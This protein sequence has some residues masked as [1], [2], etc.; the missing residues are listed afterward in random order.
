MS[1]FSFDIEIRSQVLIMAK[2]SLD[3]ED[4]DYWQVAPIITELLS[5]RE[6]SVQYPKIMSM[7]IL[8]FQDNT[9]EIM[10]PIEISYESYRK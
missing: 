2:K 6:Y 7:S 3:K 8:L 9:Y 10:D 1:N 4:P 5:H